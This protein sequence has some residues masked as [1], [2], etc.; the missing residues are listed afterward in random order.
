M[1]LFPGYTERFSKAF[2]PAS[3]TGAGPS[4]GLNVVGFQEL[5]EALNLS[6]T[7]LNNLISTIN[8]ALQEKADL[9]ILNTLLAAGGKAGPSFP[10]Q[11][12]IQMAVVAAQ[13][14][15][16][17]SFLTGSNAFGVEIDLEKLGTKDDLTKAYH[18]GAQ[19]ADIGDTGVARGPRGRFVKS[20]QGRVTLPWMGGEN[21]SSLM[22]S[23]EKRYEFWYT[24][25]NG[26]PYKGIDTSELWPTTVRERVNVWYGMGK[27]PQWLLLQYGQTEWAPVI[28]PQPIIET[29]TNVMNFVIYETLEKFFTE[30]INRIEKA[31]FATGYGVDV[32]GS[33]DIA[34]KIEKLGK[35]ASRYY[36]SRD[37][38]NIA[39]IG[40]VDDAAIIDLIRKGMG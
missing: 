16:T 10:Q 11:Y 4:I 33:D 27:A 19:Y 17:T 31:T 29:I 40:F 32:A 37:A 7:Q 34:Y 21:D 12:T 14:N 15:L 20:Q 1:P 13:L 28:R 25:F 5:I 22:N 39:T 23:V 35:H 24:L 6:V 2:K 9:V 36:G 18:Y 26:Q 8:P 38:M 30:L 3:F